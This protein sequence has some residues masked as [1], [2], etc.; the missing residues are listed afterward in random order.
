[1]NK[2]IAYNPNNCEG[3][4]KYNTKVYQILQGRVSGTSYDSSINSPLRAWN[5]YIT[6]F[7]LCQNNMGIYKCNKL[8]EDA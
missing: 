6:H 5:G 8:L 2:L 1:M 4:S 7:F 3:F